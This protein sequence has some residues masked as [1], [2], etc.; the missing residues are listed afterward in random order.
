[1]P[2]IA[3]FYP[4]GLNTPASQGYKDMQNDEGTLMQCH[5]TLHLAA[6]NFRVIMK[7]AQQ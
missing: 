5:P 7:S 2:G 4:C 6:I 3:N 1:M